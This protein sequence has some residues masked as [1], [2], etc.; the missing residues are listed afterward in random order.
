MKTIFLVVLAC[1]LFIN[2]RHVNE[3]PY[4]GRNFGSNKKINDIL[5]ITQNIPLERFQINNF[6]QT[7]IHSI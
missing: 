6:N 2:T 5:K 7:V 1:V 3:E 4:F